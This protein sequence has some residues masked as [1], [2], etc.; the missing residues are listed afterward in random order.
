MPFSGTFAASADQNRWEK[1]RF[2]AKRKRFWA[3][4]HECHN[5]LP[6][7]NDHAW[8]TLTWLHENEKEDQINRVSKE[9]NFTTVGIWQIV[10]L[11]FCET[12]FGTC[13]C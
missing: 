13:P 3:C 7:A 5:L 2:S 9:Q 1:N 4:E 8:H 11:F 12:K 6:T 10:F